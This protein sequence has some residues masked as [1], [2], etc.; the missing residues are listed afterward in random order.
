M[1]LYHA[2]TELEE[3]STRQADL[4]E[5][6]V[7][8][9]VCPQHGLR[10]LRYQQ[11]QNRGGDDEQRDNGNEGHAHKPELDYNLRVCGTN[12]E[13]SAERVSTTPVIKPLPLINTFMSIEVV[14]SYYIGYAFSDSKTYSKK[15]LP[16]LH[17]PFHM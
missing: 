5:L 17:L 12:S 1:V 14:M 8:S 2:E 4:V 3:G 11:Q 10:T 15:R 13:E 7:P 6:H 16:I 9:V